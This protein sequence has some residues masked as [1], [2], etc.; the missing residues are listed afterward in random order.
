MEPELRDGSSVDAVTVVSVAAVPPHVFVVDPLSSIS[1]SDPI[2]PMSVALG[3]RVCN[4]D[5]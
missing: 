3:R 5:I 2:A 1:Q 4:D